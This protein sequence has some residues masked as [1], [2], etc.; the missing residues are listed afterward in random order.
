MDTTSGIPDGSDS[1]YKSDPLHPVTTFRSALQAYHSCNSFDDEMRYR[2]LLRELVNQ[3]IGF[4]DLARRTSINSKSL[5]RMLSR[6]GNPT[7]R[8]MVRIICALQVA[9]D[10]TVTV[11]VY[12]ENERKQNDRTSGPRQSFTR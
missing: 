3:T 9:L 1:V 11:N 4:E 12:V 6:N 2:L 7:C 8:N 5:H 10:I